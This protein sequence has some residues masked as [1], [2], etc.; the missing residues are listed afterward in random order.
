MA[1][2]FKVVDRGQQFLLPPSLL[3]WLPADHQVWFVIDAVASMDTTVFTSRARLGGAGQAPYDPRMLLALLIWAYA[4]GVTSS[5]QV[6]RRCREDIAFMVIS[7][8]AR[9]DHATIAR[10]RKDHEAAFET[11]FT[12][13]LMLCGRAGMGGLAHIAIDGTKLVA[14]ASR[15]ATCDGEALRS[16]VRRLL[17]QAEADDTVEDEHQGPDNGNDLPPDLRDPQQRAATINRLL[18]DAAV[19]PDPDRAKARTSAAR[20]LNRTVALCDDLARRQHSASQPVLDK[21]RARLAKA[22]DRLA[23]TTAQITATNQA[24]QARDKELA[25]NGRALPGTRPVPVDQHAHVRAAVASVQRATAR[26]NEKTAAITDNTMKVNRTDPDC[27]L[28][29]RHDGGFIPAYNAQLA[30]T[31]DHLILAVHLTQ[32]TNDVAQATTMITKTETAVNLLRDETNQPTLT[33]GTLLFDAGYNS[34]ANLTTPGPDR[35]IAQSTRRRPA[36][37]APPEQ[38]P[39]HAPARD[40]MAWRHTTTEGRN[41][42]RKRGST[43]EPVNAHLK[44]RRGLRRLARRGLTAATAELHL[45][46][47]VT[48][49]LRLHS[50]TATT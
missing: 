17:A 37:T 9:P 44:D 22:Q 49:L 6:E 13:V 15:N 31:A 30:V 32:D 8:L 48:N 28:M 39:P 45:A 11:L 41:L 1:K 27:R 25:A 35:L 47:A 19:D 5:R 20:R 46:A 42:Y 18:A 36:G 29:P 34:D 33:I 43:V 21:A 23:R 4:G 38:P 7:G 50:R 40:H 10:F 2:G 24:R 12:Q 14:N 26:L 3:D 16:M